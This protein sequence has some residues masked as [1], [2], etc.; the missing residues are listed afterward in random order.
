MPELRELSLAQHHSTQLPITRAPV[1]SHLSHLQ[2]PG[3]AESSVWHQRQFPDP[4]SS[5]SGWTRFHS[6]RE[7]AGAQPF[8]A[9]QSS[10]VHLSLSHCRDLLL[11]QVNVFHFDSPGFS[12]GFP[13]QSICAKRQKVSPQLLPDWN[14]DEEACRAHLEQSQGDLWLP[15]K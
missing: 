10:P 15:L 13:G 12:W 7:I 8:G 6:I 9:L 2:P 5:P 4:L 3:P 14:L 1:I 11:F